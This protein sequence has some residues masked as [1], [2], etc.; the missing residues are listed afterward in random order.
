M[1]LC[2]RLRKSHLEQHRLTHTGERP[3]ACSWPGCTYKANR[4][5]Q[6][7]AR[8]WPF[9]LCGRPTETEALSAERDA[10]RA[11]AYPHWIQAFSVPS[12]RLQL[13]GLTEDD[14]HI[15]PTA[16]QKAR[17]DKFKTIDRLFFFF[18]APTANS[19][20]KQGT[21]AIVL[22]SHWQPGRHVELLGGD[23]TS[24]QTLAR[25]VAAPVPSPPLRVA[26]PD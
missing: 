13:R 19:S 26:C 15:P 16:M 22:L 18:A 10:R 8:F 4:V 24:C 1:A 21:I 3:F 6:M 25:T 9:V 5:R 7:R 14:A 20:M 11:H 12:P 2:S 17:L 23:F